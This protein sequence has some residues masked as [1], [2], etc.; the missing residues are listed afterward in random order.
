MRKFN[1]LSLLL[2]STLF[3]AVSCTKEGPEGPVGATGAQGPAGSNGAPGPA[4]PPGPSGGATYSTWQVTTAANWETTP[5]Y[6]VEF[7]YTRTAPSV[8]QAIIDQ[9]VVL[10]YMKGDPTYEGTPQFN[11]VF[12]LPYSIGTGF[13]WTDIYD[14]GIEAP[15]E[16]LFFYK[17]DFAWTEDELGLISF[18]YITIPGTVA[19]KSGEKRYGGYTKEELKAMPYEDVIRTFHIP[20][21]GSNLE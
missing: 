21:N 14:F 11:T 17:S 5:D 7:M 15:G 13:G 8:T 10:A 1:S 3:I 12:Q 4:G 9:G 19:G 18:R 2:L 16:I 20:E 6:A